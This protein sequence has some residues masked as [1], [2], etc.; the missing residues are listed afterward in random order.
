[1]VSGQLQDR[2]YEDIKDI[3]LSL[4]LVSGHL[5]EPHY[6][7]IKDFPWPLTIDPA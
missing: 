5:Q 3:P 1:M 4:L 7:D 2:H 6:E